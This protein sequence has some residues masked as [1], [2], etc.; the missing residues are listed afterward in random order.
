MFHMYIKK[1]SCN[2]SV[3]EY[4]KYHIA[5]NRRYLQQKLR[6]M[7][8]LLDHLP[9]TCLKVGYGGFSPFKTTHKPPGLVFGKPTVCL[10]RNHGQFFVS[11]FVL[12]VVGFSYIFFYLAFVVKVV[13]ASAAEVALE[14][15]SMD[16]QSVQN[17]ASLWKICL[18]VAVGRISRYMTQ[19]TSVYYCEVSLVITFKG[20]RH[21]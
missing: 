2:Y 17:T 3:V 7:Q 21:C 8:W 19:R 5:G 16:L 14:G 1:T 6:T 15:T 10:L 18:A 9:D 20:I 13:V 11:V 4:V 12:S